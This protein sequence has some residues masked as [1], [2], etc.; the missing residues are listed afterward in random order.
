MHH[1]VESAFIWKHLQ[2]YQLFFA[3]PNFG[4]RNCQKSIFT[5]LVKAH[6]DQFLME[7]S[8]KSFKICIFQ[9][10]LFSFRSKVKIK[11]EQ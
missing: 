9:Q 5:S 6:S 2:R 7:K 1:F 4:E 10:K 11:Y 8:K 3:N